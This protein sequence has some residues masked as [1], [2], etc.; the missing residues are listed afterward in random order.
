MLVV[1]ATLDQDVARADR[2]GIFGDER[3]LLCQRRC[4]E[5]YGHECEY[6][7]LLHHHRHHHRGSQNA[8]RLSS[9]MVTG[10]SLTSSTSMCDWNSPVSTRRPPSRRVSATAS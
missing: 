5:T 4:R 1:E 10:P 9:S 3:T 6:E 7:R 2:L 8:F